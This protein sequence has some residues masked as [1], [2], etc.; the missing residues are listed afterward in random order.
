MKYQQSF[1]FSSSY[2]KLRTGLLN[3]FA[4]ETLA[5][6]GPNAFPEIQG[7]KVNTTVFVL[8]REPDPLRRAANV[9]TCFRL[10]YEPDAEAKRL[11]F[12]KALAELKQQEV[13]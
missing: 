4:T 13:Q 3:E 5:H 12:E 6:T 8:S 10:V 11:A 2:Q 9:G 7:E 1:M